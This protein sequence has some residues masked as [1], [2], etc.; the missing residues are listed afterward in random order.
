MPRQRRT[1]SEVGSAKGKRRPR[2]QF[3]TT[4]EERRR[5]DE[6]KLV[7]GV[8]SYAEVVRVAVRVLG[9]II[10]QKEDGYSLQLVKNGETKLVE[11]LL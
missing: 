8:Q 2:H 7:V 6:I 1:R 3:E 4:I 11:W 10:R 5:M 9:W